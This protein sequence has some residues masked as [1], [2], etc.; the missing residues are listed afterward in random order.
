MTNPLDESRP[1]EEAERYREH[2]MSDHDDVEDDVDDLGDMDDEELAEHGRRIVTELARRVRGPAPT[3][4]PQAW[5]RVE[6]LVDLALAERAQRA[7]ER[8]V[9]ARHQPPPHAT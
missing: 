7:V 8:I 4:G 2:L 5:E 1:L 9:A 6:A 3:D